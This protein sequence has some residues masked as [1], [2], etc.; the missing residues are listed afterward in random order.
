MLRVA[1]ATALLLGLCFVYCG[2]T[3]AE[4]SGSSAGV[5]EDISPPSEN[6]T[7]FGPAIGEDAITEGVP[8]SIE[9]LF[10]SNLIQV[11]RSCS[12]VFVGK[13]VNSRAEEPRRNGI[14]YTEY[15][16]SVLEYLKGDTGKKTILLRNLGGEI[17]ELKRGM[18]SAFSFKLEVGKTYLV[19]LRPN[20]ERYVLPIVRV[21]SVLNAGEKIADEKGRVLLDTYL[22]G[23]TIQSVESLYTPLIYGY[24]G[25]DG[26]VPPPMPISEPDSVSINAVIESGE[27]VATRYGERAKRPY[28][29]LETLKA[30]L[31][32]SLR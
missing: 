17:P 11:Y 18:A 16:F 13:V 32:K 20:Y 10:S 30:F 8:D 25:V 15:A 22:N 1:L 21:F 28:L 14:I 2:A 26:R 23:E 6:K 7:P 9:K 29:K 5:E 24:R 19:F 3:Y 31:E 4:E 12:T 27:S